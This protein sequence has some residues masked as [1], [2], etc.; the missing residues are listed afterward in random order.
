MPVRD[1][2]L[3]RRALFRH[4]RIDLAHEHLCDSAKRRCGF[5]G[6]IEHALTP[7][8]EA[9]SGDFPQVFDEHMVALLLSFAEQSD[10]PALSR[11]PRES[12]RA[13]T[14]VRVCDAVERARPQYNYRYRNRHLQHHLPRGVHHA[15]RV[16]RRSARTFGDRSLTNP[17]GPDPSSR[18]G[19]VRLPPPRAPCIPPRACENYAYAIHRPGWR[20]CP[21]E[22]E[23]I[24]RVQRIVRTRGSPIP[25]QVQVG[26]PNGDDICPPGLSKTGNGATDEPSDPHLQALRV[27][28]SLVRAL[29]YRPR[30][31]LRS[32]FLHRST[33]RNV[34]EA[35]YGAGAAV[36]R[37]VWGDN[38]TPVWDGAAIIEATHSWFANF[39]GPAAKCNSRRL[40]SE[41]TALHAKNRED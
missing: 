13:V 31:L 20:D 22:G 16:V 34:T 40:D 6:D 28:R 5:G 39:I 14:I 8:G 24:R 29:N 12:V 38:G 30:P 33:V 4:R 25:Q 18:T 3:A 1:R 36:Q 23:R 15:V 27:G 21:E 32:G 17:D 41:E 35:R 11:Q 19:R 26:P 10:L 9:A 2:V 37:P 7:M